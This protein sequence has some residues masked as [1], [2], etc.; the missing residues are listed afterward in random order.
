MTTDRQRDTIIEM[1]NRIDSKEMLTKLEEV[2]FSY[3]FELE[4]NNPISVE[5]FK[6]EM[7]RSIQDVKM[8]RTK[9]VEELENEIAGWS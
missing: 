7:G 1:L 9:S 8:G 6:E 4:N 3:H 2:L 5:K